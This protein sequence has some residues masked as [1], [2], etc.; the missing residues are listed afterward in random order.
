VTGQLP[1]TCFDVLCLVL[2]V[3]SVRR[4]ARFGFARATVLI[5]ALKTPT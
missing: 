5:A 4:K 1:F 2:H 3:L